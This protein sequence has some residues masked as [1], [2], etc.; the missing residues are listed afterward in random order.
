MA[1]TQCQESLTTVTVLAVKYVVKTAV[2]YREFKTLVRPPVRL[3][4]GTARRGRDGS[5]SLPCLAT[6][7]RPRPETLRPRLACGG[8]ASF[9]CPLPLR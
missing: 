2:N 3:E 1:S 9:R 6:T 7:L 4:K 8:Y 5:R